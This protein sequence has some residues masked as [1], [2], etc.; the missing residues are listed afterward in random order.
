MNNL[1]TFIGQST[2]THFHAHKF[3]LERQPLL[4]IIPEHYCY[5][6]FTPS[7]TISDELDNFVNWIQTLGAVSGSHTTEIIF[8][9]ILNIQLILSPEELR[10]SIIRFLNTLLYRNKNSIPEQLQ[11][12][13]LVTNYIHNQEFK[14]VSNPF[15]GNYSETNED[16]EE[17]SD[18]QQEK[19]QQQVFV[20]NYNFDFELY[21]PELF[22]EMADINA[23]L[24][25]VTGLTAALTNQNNRVTEKIIILYSL[26]Q[27]LLKLMNKQSD[28][29]VK[30]QR[31][32]ELRL[33][34]FTKD[35]KGLL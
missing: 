10:R 20:A 16:T 9:D 31:L 19:V 14:E 2:D 11:L 3:K 13:Q 7:D 21:L 12:I 15:D 33:I 1:N 24:A 8:E 18:N 35:S 5:L 26:I 4:K 34:E 17:L 28:I 27:E 22:K 29:T 6:C 25:A 23:V 32:N 30:E